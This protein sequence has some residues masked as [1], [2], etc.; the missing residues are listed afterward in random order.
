MDVFD[1]ASDREQQERDAAIAA[2]LDASRPDSLATGYCMDCG[3]EIEAERLAVVP[4]APRCVSCQQLAETRQHIRT[5][6]RRA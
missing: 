2:V 3:D 5:G 4:H 6:G 1:R